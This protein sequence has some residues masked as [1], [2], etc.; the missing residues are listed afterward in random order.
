M[1][2]ARWLAVLLLV[3]LWG[4]NREPQPVPKTDNPFERISRASSHKQSPGPAGS[5][6]SDSRNKGA[7]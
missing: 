2:Q 7:P 6:Q 4:C 3:G 5:P 1:R